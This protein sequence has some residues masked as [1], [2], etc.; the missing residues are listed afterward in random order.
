MPVMAANGQG[1]WGVPT[2]CA[3]CGHN[4]PHHAYLPCTPL[5]GEPC[6]CPT[7]LPTKHWFETVPNHMFFAMD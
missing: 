1:P 5:S 3:N 4:D 7:F 2:E 6:D